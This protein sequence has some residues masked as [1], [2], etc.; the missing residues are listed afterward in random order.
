M[1]SRQV[2]PPRNHAS[3]ARSRMPPP[4]SA[5][6]GVAG[7]CKPAAQLVSP[8]ARIHQMRVRV[9]ESG[10]HRAASRVD[11]RASRRVRHVACA[12]LRRSHEHDPTL[13]CRDRRLRDG[14]CVGLI[15]P[16]PGPAPGAGDY[17]EGVGDNAVGEHGV[18]GQAPGATREMGPEPRP[19][20]IMPLSSR[21]VASRA[22]SVA[23]VTPSKATRLVLL[24]WPATSVT[25]R[26]GRW[27]AAASASTS[28]A[29]AAPSTGAAASFTARRPSRA[30]NRRAAGPWGDA[31]RAG[32]AGGV[33]RRRPSEMHDARCKGPGPRQKCPTRNPVGLLAVGCQAASSIL[34]VVVTR[35]QPGSSP[36][37]AWRAGS[38]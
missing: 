8:I 1:R 7:A 11:D 22:S 14:T 9:H 27:N 17:F 23:G 32:C 25:A 6:L 31:H 26:L 37:E 18:G 2:G 29:L 28:A 10:H 19:P 15:G 38:R 24:R 36:P 21:M 5:M 34:A 3:P 35:T 33:G 16:A 20:V 13:V 12:G 30:R 4:S